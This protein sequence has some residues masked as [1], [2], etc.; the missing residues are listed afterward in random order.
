MDNYKFFLTCCT[1]I[2]N[3]GK[4]IQEWVEHYISQGV[5]YFYIIDNGSTDNTLEILKEYDNI[6]VFH[7]H[8]KKAEDQVLMYID[9]FIPVIKKSKWNI[10]VDADELIFVNKKYDTISNYLKYIKED[11]SCIYIIWKM[12]LGKD[13]NIKKMTDIKNRFNYDYLNIWT[14]ID[15]TN[16][17]NWN[18]NLKYFLMFGK[19]I[20]KPNDLNQNVIWVHKQNVKGKMFNNFGK[21]E[22]LTPDT[23]AQTTDYINEKTLNDAPIYLN[24]YFMKN[25]E[26]YSKRIKNED[27]NTTNDT[28]IA[29]NKAP[30][31]DYHKF[32]KDMYNMDEKFIIK[33][34]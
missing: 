27:Y 5:E 24:H 6:T 19:S 23:I 10:L 11:I 9:N 3:E 30:G 18:L 31:W 16:Q 4:Y 22:N 26:E 15:K 13:N 8:R 2:K 21:L 33:E 25:Q 14:G 7:D 32:L 20:F 17:I 28:Y 12:Y 29:H 1:I 34:K